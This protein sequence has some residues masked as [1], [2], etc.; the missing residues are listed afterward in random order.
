[1]SIGSRC[2]AGAWTRWPGCPRPAQTQTPLSK[3]AFAPPLGN[4]SQVALVSCV[5]TSTISAS[6]G[7]ESISP[8]AQ[9]PSAPFPPPH[10]HTLS[11]THS[12]LTTTSASRGLAILHANPITARTT[13]FFFSS[14]MNPSPRTPVRLSDAAGSSF[15]SQSEEEGGGVIFVLMA[16]VQSGVV[17]HSHHHHTSLPSPVF[18]FGPGL[19]NLHVVFRYQSSPAVQ[20]PLQP[21]GLPGG[22]N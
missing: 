5:I 8:T 18:F 17:K 20:S 4:K 7:G 12:W 1:M 13:G 19:E 6:K 9:Q 2:W 11:D 22:V 3:A 14:A 16:S 21:P 10:T 15:Y